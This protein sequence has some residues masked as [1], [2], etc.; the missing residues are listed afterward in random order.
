MIDVTIQV[1]ISHALAGETEHTRMEHP[2][3]AVEKQSGW[4]F[5]YT[6]EWA[7]GEKVPTILKLSEAG[8]SLLRQGNVKM[9]Q[10]FQTGK[11]SESMYETPHGRFRLEIYTRKLQQ[12]WDEDAGMPS[13]ARI[14]YQQWLDG[15]YLGEYELHYCFQRKE[16]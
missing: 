5:S 10:E 6:E 8:I 3:K 14:Y 1:S 13:E 12:V 2:G 16:A 4:F 11:Q 15:Q 9:R 7:E